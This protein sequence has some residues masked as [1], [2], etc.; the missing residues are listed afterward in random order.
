M[1]R[2]ISD[3]EIFVSVVELGSFASAARA[4]G[5]PNSTVT[6]QVAT[7]EARLGVELIHRTTRRLAATQAGTLLFD[8][9]RGIRVEMDDAE[10]A[11]RALGT[12]VSGR[13]RVGVANALASRVIA[14][15]LPA[16]NRQFPDAGI[17]LVLGSAPLD[18]IE[19]RIDIVLR[20][21]PMPLRDSELSARALGELEV[22]L[23][24]S[25][26]YTAVHGM[27]E[28]PE[29]LALHRTLALEAHRNPA[30]FRWTLQSGAR[31]VE[32]PIAPWLVA[33]DPLPLLEAMRAD[34]GI[35]MLSPAVGQA[36]IA[37]VDAVRVLPEWEGPRLTLHALYPRE[38]LRSPTV[39]ALIDFLAEALAP[40][41]GALDEPRPPAR[42]AAR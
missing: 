18:L 10:R 20:L 35:V 27:P 15:M 13:L 14:P 31:R 32:A 30:G 6:R 40:G 3:I 39:R 17:E 33:G 28:D 21:S 38:R 2:Q 9:C 16:F 34:G 11:V 12:S 4:L 23:F 41:V 42:R 19:H 29:A 1:G 8:R 36:E 5:L 37:A 22:G 24:A 26:G 7:L 25:P